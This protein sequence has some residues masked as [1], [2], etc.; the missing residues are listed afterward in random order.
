MFGTKVGQR[1]DKLKKVW[2]MS[3]VQH[4]RTVYHS[5]GGVYIQIGN[6][7]FDLRKL[8]KN[9]FIIGFVP[10]GASFNEFIKPFV[11]D[12]QLLEKEI[13]MKINNIEYLIIGGLGVV[14]ADLPQGNDLCGIKRHNANHG[15][16]NCFVLREQ[17]SDKNYDCLQNARY[18]HQ[19]KKLQQQYNL[20]KSI[21]EKKDFATKYGISI[22]PSPFSYL[23]FNPFQQIPQ[24]AYH[25]ISGKIACLMKITMDL[26]SESG[27]KLFIKNWKYFEFPSTWSKMPSPT[28]H[29]RSHFMSDYQR[30]TMIFPFIL[31]RFLSSEHIKKESLE[32]IKILLNIHS[33]VV[34]KKIIEVWSKMAI[35]TKTIF[36]LS[37]L[38]DDY[39]KL[40]ILLQEERDLLIKIFPEFKNLPNMHINFHLIQHALSYANLINISV[41]VK[42]MVY[43]IFKNFA[44]H[45]NKKEIDFDLIKRYITM[46]GIR[47]FF[48]NNPNYKNFNL[49]ND[50]YITSGLNISEEIEEETTEKLT[51]AIVRAIIS[52]KGNDTNNYLFFYIKWY[53]EIPGSENNLLGGCS[54]FKLCDNE[55]WDV[56]FPINI[57]D[58]Q[59]R[60][61]FVHNCTTK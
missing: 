5:L 43:R 34:P 3:C 37:F 19:I 11:R 28:S 21:Q 22:Q 25:A 14:T 38:N 58:Q 42:E 31:N 15:C 2:D 49:F 7:P 51:Y 54:Q 53:N 27:K 1:W 46:E 13:P 8:L 61:H 20:L 36:S 12:I 6:M 18:L 30:F 55:K 41:G 59:Q 45:T 57:V 39:K 10:F 32:K 26:L 9:H 56:I 60:V 50:W 16:R 33:K 23:K 4:C 24:D 44:S 40:E 35:C 48:D 17:L 47:N 52:H 29:S